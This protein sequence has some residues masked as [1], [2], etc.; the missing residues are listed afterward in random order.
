MLAGYAWLGKSVERS[1]D[2]S[3]A[4]AA[5][6]NVDARF[7]LVD[8]LRLS[9]PLLAGGMSYRLPFESG[10]ELRAGLSLGAMLVQ[11]RDRVA[12][13]ARADGRVTDATVLD[14]GVRSGSADLFVMPEARLEYRTGRVHVGFGLLV[15]Y[16]F[17]QGPNDEHGAT[18]VDRPDLCAPTASVHC[19]PFQSVTERE[20]A[21]GRFVAFVPSLVAGLEL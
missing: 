20:R 16:F 1:F 10:L 17:L 13:E 21:Y 8:R 15:P 7:D 9:G 19:A 14:S 4:I 5:T 2:A 18:V 12:G 11:S 3:Y 6:Q